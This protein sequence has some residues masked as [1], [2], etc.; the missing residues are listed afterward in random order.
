MADSGDEVE[1]LGS[2]VLAE[3]TDGVDEA[4][5][6]IPKS[7][8]EVSLASFV[9][10]A[11]LNR[12]N[13]GSVLGKLGND[14]FTEVAGA[15]VAGVVEA[16]VVEAGEAVSAVSSPWLGVED[17]PKIGVVG[18]VAVPAD[19]SS[20]GNGLFATE[21]A[22]AGVAGVE[23]NPLLGAVLNA[24]HGS[25]V[26]GLLLGV[27]GPVTPEI[28]GVVVSRSTRFSSSGFSVVFVP[29]IATKPP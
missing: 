22:A 20:G 3:S 4:G 1:R 5:S 2:V 14:A 25:V 27:N 10:F 8:V 18:K 6:A 12:G 9:S 13:D 24:A 17:A 29:L 26:D 15:A 7:G 19:A 21:L 23:V 11:E 16:G 28:S